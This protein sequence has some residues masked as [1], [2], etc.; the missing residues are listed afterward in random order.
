MKQKLPLKTFLCSAS[1]ATVLGGE[2]VSSNGQSSV[3][4][5]RTPHGDVVVVVGAS[6]F[7]ML[8]TQHTR[9]EAER[10]ASATMATQIASE[11]AHALRDKAWSGAAWSINPP[12]LIEVSRST[13]FRFQMFLTWRDFVRRILVLAGF[14]SE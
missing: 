9:E 11:T 6:T 1:T 13:F 4:R 2:L 3:W 7:P 8:L 5:V 10:T 12:V 14:R